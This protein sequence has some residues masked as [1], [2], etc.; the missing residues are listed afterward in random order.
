MVVVAFFFM[1]G[2]SI[3]SLLFQFYGYFNVLV[4][5]GNALICNMT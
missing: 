2:V 1:K 5:T 3:F 4:I